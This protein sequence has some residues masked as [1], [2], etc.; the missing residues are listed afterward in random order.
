MTGLT[1]PERMRL[2]PYVGGEGGVSEKNGRDEGKALSGV[3]ID[4]R[5]LDEKGVSGQGEMV[6]S[7][8]GI[9]IRRGNSEMRPVEGSM[10]AVVTVFPGGI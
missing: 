7:G 6:A 10:T 3:L 4:S 8:G 5:V 2:L 9:A 1:V